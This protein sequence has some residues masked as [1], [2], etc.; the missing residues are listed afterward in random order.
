MPRRKI[1]NIASHKSW[2]WNELGV[3]ALILLEILC[4]FWPLFDI[5]I[6]VS[7]A[8]AE[9]MTIRR[10]ARSTHIIAVALPPV[11]LNNCTNRRPDGFYIPDNSAIIK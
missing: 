2:R 6:H 4:C 3:A 5:T 9:F 8:K 10:V 7:V 1:A 11:N